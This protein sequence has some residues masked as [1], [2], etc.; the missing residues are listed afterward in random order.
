[1]AQNVGK[2]TWKNHPDNPQRWFE[3]RNERYVRGN[4]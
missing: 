3:P 2:A 4:K 1:M